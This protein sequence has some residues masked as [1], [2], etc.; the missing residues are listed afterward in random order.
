MKMHKCKS[1]AITASL[2]AITWAVTANAQD[3]QSEPPKATASTEA[4]DVVDSANEIVVTASRR[5]EKVQNVPGTVTAISGE[6][7]QKQGVQS[8]RDY[9]TLVP[10][11]SQRDSGAPGFGTIIIRGLNSGP[12]Q[13]TSTAAMYI[14][15]AP[16]TASGYLSA[17]AVLTPDPDIA[18][19][20]QLEVLKGPQGTLFG[21]N[22]LGGIVRIVTNHPDVNAFSGFAQAEGSTVD[23]GGQ[24]YAV[25]G[26]LNVPIIEGTLAVRANG[27][28]R[29]LPGWTDNVGLNIKDANTSTIKGGRFGVRF[30]PTENLTLD[31]SVLIED[32]D[33]NGGTA[34]DML[35]GTLI[36]RTGRYTYR[37]KFETPSAAK[38]RLYSGSG[39]YDFGPV[40][41][42]STVNWSQYRTAIVSDYSESYLPYLR[43]AGLGAIL[44][45]DGG[46]RGDISPNMDKFTAET[47][48]VSERLGPI[49]FV[50][51][52]FYTNEHSTYSTTLTAL[53]A[54]NRP[55]TA[56]FDV[57][58]RAVTTSDYEEVAGY[59][60]ATFYLTDNFDVG[61]GV[62]VSHNKQFAQIGGPNAVNFY[63]PR[64]AQDFRFSDDVATYL[65]TA[66]WR[67]TPNV[68]LFVRAASGY[69][70]GGP[71]TNSTPPAGAQ[72]LI[73]SDSVWNYEA[74][75]KS[76]LL[77]GRLTANASVFHI[78]WNDI[79]LNTNY[80][81]TVLG[82]NGGK[83]KIDGF[84][85]E[86]AM[87]PTSLLTIGANVGYT[88]ARI[89]NIDPAA[90][91]VMGARSGD[92]LPL[93]PDWTVSMTADH[94]VPFSEKVQGNLGGT[95]RFR[96][97]MPNSFPGS[98]LDPN[99]KLPSLT[100]LDL[101]ASV[102][103]D[104]RYTLQLRGENI[105][106]TYGLTSAT[107]GAVYQGQPVPTIATTARPRTLVASISA[108]F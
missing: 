22:S 95:L 45:A 48:L 21:A 27:V 6:Q 71:Q 49:E 82:G 55:L 85:L 19:L 32:I 8:F 80:G 73:R 41:L 96:S 23:G 90:T 105:F 88:D 92:Q 57:V 1:I 11:L 65:A 106:N 3:Q 70:P 108:A 7:L 62:R 58:L 46:I 13:L 12:Q 43:L 25:R 99:L 50:V 15:D 75:V 29:R 77:G 83:A 94:Q 35:T 30:T 79:Q 31:A 60:N 74:G 39:S 66:R 84:E 102:T 56:P 20:S 33:N 101:R 40:Q 5:N 91:A 97:D 89:S 63:A 2:V 14:D 86:L 103:F 98:L 9:V 51:G 59:A 47:R 17:T 36:P 37:T 93:T 28:Y 53:N 100:T 107:T 52:G 67:P 18:D 24:G 61:G 44:P 16:F 87:R 81:G 42:I 34:Q 78:D 26:T 69:R 38:Y 4:P 64:P 10:G 68:S 54:S 72:T 104:K 76:N